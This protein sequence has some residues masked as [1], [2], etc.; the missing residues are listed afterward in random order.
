MT[1]TPYF[2]VLSGHIHCIFYILMEIIYKKWYFDLKFERESFK[3]TDGGTIALDWVVDHEGGLPRK[4][5]PRPI[6]C[7]ISGLSGGNDNLY[8]YSIM[9]EAV[10]KGYKAVVINFRGASGMPLTSAMIY[11]MNTW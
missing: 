1:Y 2:L 5:S 7:V 4:N 3:L 10:N 8:L 11:W 9:K 6:L